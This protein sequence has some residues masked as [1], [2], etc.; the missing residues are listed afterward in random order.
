VVSEIHWEDTVDTRQPVAVRQVVSEEVAQEMQRMLVEA[1]RIGMPKAMVTGYDM[2]GKSGTSGVPD[3]EGYKNEETIAS[4]V[5]FGP[6]PNPRFVILVKYER[7]K[8]GLWGADA[9]AP[10]FRQM[11]S[12]LL[13]YYGIPPTNTV[14]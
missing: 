7:P 14:G 13:D 2:A 3:R 5:G 12:F 9:A 11:A 4:F 6:I 10:A 1:V 8:E